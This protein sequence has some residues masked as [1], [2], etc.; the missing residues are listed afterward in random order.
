MKLSIYTFTTVCI[1]DKLVMDKMNSGFKNT[2]ET[3]P[4]SIINITD[5]II[6]ESFKIKYF[7]KEQMDKN[8]IY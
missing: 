2:R 4:Q 1:N 5:D 8:L 6:A 7:F 3:D